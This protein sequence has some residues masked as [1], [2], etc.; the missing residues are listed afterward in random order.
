MEASGVPLGLASEGSFGPHPLI[1]FSGASDYEM[2][3]FVDA[4]I[5]ITVVEG[6]LTEETNFSHWRARSLD[7]LEN[8]LKKA[9]FP[10]HSLIVRPNE[11]L[12]PGSLFKGI[13]DFGTLED[14][15][16]SCAA[17]SKDGWAHVETDMR[18]H[19]NPTRQK[20]IRRTA[21]R[22]AR[23]LST[24]CPSCKAPGWGQIGSKMGLPCI[25]C[26]TPTEMIKHEI[27]GCA[28]CNYTEIRPRSDGRKHA[29]QGQCPY[30]NP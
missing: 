11:G 18:A 3:A 20:I 9:G 4:E 29:E 5:G 24:F 22:L 27:H 6:Y 7:D 17:T 21:F 15:V 30:C 8:F 1:P 28:R 26:H 19:V 16:R 14:V 25:S 2:I 12:G 13:A 10:S 23:R